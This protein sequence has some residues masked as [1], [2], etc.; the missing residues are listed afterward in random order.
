MGEVSGVFGYMSDENVIFNVTLIFQII[1][2]LVFCDV[3][4][5]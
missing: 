3:C 5:V 2:G 4:I 1:C